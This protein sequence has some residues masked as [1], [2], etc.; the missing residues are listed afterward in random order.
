MDRTAN[1]LIRDEL[2]NAGEC[3]GTYEPMT[4]HGITDKTLFLL[5]I[6][7]V[8]AVLAWKYPP[9]DAVPVILGSVVGAF[10]IGFVTSFNITWSPFTAPVFAIFERIFLGAFSGWMN[11][12]YPRIVAQAVALTFAVFFL[13]LLIFRA[14]LIRVTEKLRLVVIGATGAI[15]LFYLAHIVLSLFG[16]PLGFVNEGG[17]TGIAFSLVVVIVASL[18][19]ILDFDYVEQSVENRL[20]KRH[21]W[22]AAFTLLVTLVW[23]YLEIIRLLMKIRML[24]KKPGR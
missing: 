1:P 4:I 17:W 20:P 7:M 22:Y 5:L 8:S 15:A 13:L 16:M 18:S 11:A 6:A 21:E 10:A 9:A 2:F 23:L 3:N 24:V 14:R 19:L 12:L